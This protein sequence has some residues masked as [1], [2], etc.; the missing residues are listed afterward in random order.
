[1]YA[2]QL[3]LAQ[4]GCRPAPPPPPRTILDTKLTLTLTGPFRLVRLKTRL[5]VATKQLLEG[6]PTAPPPDQAVGC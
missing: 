2:N 1:M 4:A 3:S 5:L 6:E